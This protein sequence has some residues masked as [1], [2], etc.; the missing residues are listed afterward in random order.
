MKMYA[1]KKGY[2]RST[3]GHTVFPYLAERENLSIDR[4]IKVTD[5]YIGK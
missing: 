5:F 1:T 3:Q 2:V 4:I